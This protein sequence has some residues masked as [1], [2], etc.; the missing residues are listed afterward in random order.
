MNY[1][2]PY[3]LLQISPDIIP[4]R[5]YLLNAKKVL[6]AKLELSSQTTI[7]IHNTEY[8]KND[9]DVVFEK[10]LA[11]TNWE[12]HQEIELNRPLKIFLQQGE[13][14]RPFVEMPTKADR[15]F[16]LFIADWYASSYQ[17]F[18]LNA[19]KGNEYY[20]LRKF[21]IE[22][23]LQKDLLGKD[24]L[25]E[26][27]FS[28]ILELRK[29]IRNLTLLLD[30]D[31]IIK[32][33]SI[34]K[35]GAYYHPDRIDCLNLLP[36]ETYQEVR[37]EYGIALVKLFIELNNEFKIYSQAGEVIRNIKYLTLTSSARAEF[38][39][40]Y[41]YYNQTYAMGGYGMKIVKAIALAVVVCVVLSVVQLFIPSS[42]NDNFSDTTA[43]IN[44]ELAFVPSETNPDSMEVAVVAI[45]SPLETLQA[46]TNPNYVINNR[47]VEPVEMKELI[48]SGS[49]LDLILFYSSTGK[50]YRW[51]YNEMEGL[52]KFAGNPAR[53]F[54][55]AFPYRYIGEAEE[56]EHHIAITNPSDADFLAFLYTE[57]GYFSV[58]LIGK[59]SSVEL[60]TNE[61]KSIII[62]D[63]GGNLNALDYCT[64][65]DLHANKA[66]PV[67][68]SNGRGESFSVSDVISYIDAP[69]T[70]LPGAAKHLVY[71]YVI[72]E[73][74]GVITGIKGEVKLDK[75]YKLKK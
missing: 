44:A 47:I 29:L 56:G 58:K 16:Y 11:E 13:W 36:A 54:E 6:L 15:D 52:E 74:S 2:S 69:N 7:S 9:L 39:R 5:Q 14:D 4:D 38:Q 1:S 64:I 53:F 60:R 63:G 12:Y 33:R 34:K 10:L 55:S 72:E 71:S 48:T 73:S 65:S 50:G 23:H 35:L 20:K 28:I 41:E 61:Q 75:K 18:V 3:D 57:G 43:A 19:I 31:R 8:T 22:T 67:F 40:C 66:L 37:N 30:D 46:G 51:Q 24:K 68:T 70:S 59:K 49:Y 21:L 26:L 42:K 27:E 25:V 17:H 62:I 32:E 45:K